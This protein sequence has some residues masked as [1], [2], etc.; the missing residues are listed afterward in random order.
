MSVEFWQE[1]EKFGTQESSRSEEYSRQD[2]VLALVGGT[3]AQERTRYERYRF[4]EAK[5]NEPAR[6]DD[7]LE[8]QTYV[9]DCRERETKATTP[10]GKPVAPEVL[11]RLEHAHAELGVEDKIVADLKDK[12]IAVGAHAS[13]REALFRAL[14]TTVQGD[15]KSGTVTLSGTR[16]ENGREAAV[17]DWSAEMHTEEETGMETTWHIKGQFVVGIAPAM[18]LSAKWSGDVDVGGHT[19][20]DGKRVDLEGSGSM[21]DDRSVTPL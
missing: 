1:G 3:P 2:E 15:F 13:M 10:E 20:R 17:F 16:V 14:V 7:S 18:T 11:Q 4:K 8:G 21:S 5:P 12:A 6:E 19:R 9:V